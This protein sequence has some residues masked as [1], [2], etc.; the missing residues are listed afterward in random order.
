MSHSQANADKRVNDVIAQR[1]FR[2]LDAP[3]SP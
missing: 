2:A 3:K 1:L